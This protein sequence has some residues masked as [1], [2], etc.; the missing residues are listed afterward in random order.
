[1]Y[2]DGQFASDCDVTG[3]I[4]LWHSIWKCITSMKNRLSFDKEICALSNQIQSRQ[5]LRN[6]CAEACCGID[7]RLSDAFCANTTVTV[8]AGHY[9]FWNKQDVLHSQSHNISLLN[10]RQI[11]LR[12]L[13]CQCVW[14]NL[15][16]FRTKFHGYN[17]GCGTL[18]SVE[19]I[20]IYL[21]LNMFVC[22]RPSVRT[23]P[24]LTVQTGKRRKLPLI[25][26]LAEMR[27]C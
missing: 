1:M 23:I 4:R 12:K 24:K 25:A 26:Q 5:N 18:I 16:Q 2:P 6:V 9:Y 8:I 19:L 3:R 13:S 15:S 14:M 27:K 17:C 20:E 7:L 21:S 10:R 22:C 11:L